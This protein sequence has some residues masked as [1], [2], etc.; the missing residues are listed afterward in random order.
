MIL[1]SNA[2]TARG[3]NIFYRTFLSHR[4]NLRL[5]IDG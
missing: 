5:K 1:N 4:K 3:A 2:E